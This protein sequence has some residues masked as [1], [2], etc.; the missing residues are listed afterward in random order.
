MLVRM[1]MHENTIRMLQL[2]LWLF[3]L[4][5]SCAGLAKIEMKVGKKVQQD[6]HSRHTMR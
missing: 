4:S 2:F 3:G 5:I 1:H 6:G